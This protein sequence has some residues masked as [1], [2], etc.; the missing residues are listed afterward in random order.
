MKIIP[1]T[2]NKAISMTLLFSIFNTFFKLNP[3]IKKY[4]AVRKNAKKVDLLAKTVRCNANSS[5]KIKS[6][7]IDFWLLIWSWFCQE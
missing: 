3:A 5:L 2:E 6:L 1:E 7:L 4:I